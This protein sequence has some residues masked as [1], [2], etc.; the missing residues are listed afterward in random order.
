MRVKIAILCLLNHVHRDHKGHVPMFP[1][2][3]ENVITSSENQQRI[4]IMSSVLLQPI[5]NKVLHYRPYYSSNLLCRCNS[6]TV[7]RCSDVSYIVI[8]SQIQVTFLSTASLIFFIHSYLFIY[9]LYP[10]YLLVR[11]YFDFSMEH[12]LIA[13]G[14][15]WVSL[16]ASRIFTCLL[17]MTLL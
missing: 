9:Y 4:I 14:S 1:S 15:L 8:R 16:M 10:V 17:T 11:F 12:R 13:K 2:F 5:L 7:A 6:L 3:F